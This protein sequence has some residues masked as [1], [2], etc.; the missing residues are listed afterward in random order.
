MLTKQI[1][2]MKQIFKIIL[3]CFVL[4][5]A[6]A[7]TD[8]SS[9][10]YYFDTDPGI[11]NGTIIDINPD[12]EIINQNF[13]IPT[14][15]LPVGN[16]QLFV[17]V[18]KTNGTA[19]LYDSKPFLVQPNNTNSYD[20][21]EAEYFVDTDPGIGNGTIVDVADV[22]NLNTNLS[23]VTT[24]LSVGTH[25][26]FVRVKNANNKWS[27]YDGKPFLVQPDNTNTSNIV[28]AEYFI[29]VDPGTGNGTSMT[30]SGA[31]VDTVV[32]IT[33]QNTLPDGQHILFVRVKN[34]NNK[35]SLYARSPFE[36][37]GALGN[38]SFEIS[39]ITVYPNPTADFIHLEIPDNNQLKGIK[40]FDYNGKQVLNTSESGKTIDISN[41]ASGTYILLL[42][43][44]KGNLTKKIIKN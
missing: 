9:V 33:T 42:E 16:H 26:L 28:E 23:V 3:L 24:G 6:N 5:F 14:T 43:T 12:S 40:M 22:A 7:Q 4:N 41:F 18:I 2:V 27:L 25:H 30:V 29:D 20:I 39:K 37:S 19:S 11:G 15:G 17:R 1:K 44:E 36:S 32:P 34:A 35:W 31:N 10:E 8:I 38:D 13:S 21:V